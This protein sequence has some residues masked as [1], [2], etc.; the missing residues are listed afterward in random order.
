M[1][2]FTT[3]PHSPRANTLQVPHAPVRV[4]QIIRPRDG[5]TVY[6]FLQAPPVMPLGLTE[7]A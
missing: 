2:G 1:D 4:A 6:Q 7:D 5:F 3:P